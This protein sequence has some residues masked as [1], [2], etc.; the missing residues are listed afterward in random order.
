M[1]LLNNKF[2]VTID[3][4]NASLT[5]GWKG[6][7]QAKVFRI[8]FNETDKHCFVKVYGS[9]MAQINEKN[10]LY[11]L[12]N[13]ALDYIDASYSDTIEQY[14]VENFGYDEFVEDDYGS[15]KKNPELTRVA[16]GL[17]EQYKRAFNIIGSNDEIVDLYNEFREEY[18]Y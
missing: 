11:Y 17:A 14:L 18:D 4:P 3:N 6:A 7:K 16:R 8:K 1:E 2:T 5:G 12:L 13:D 15:I 9:S 10:A